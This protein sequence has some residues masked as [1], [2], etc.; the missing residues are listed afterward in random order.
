M[1]EWNF[2]SAF[3]PWPMAVCHSHLLIHVAAEIILLQQW[4]WS[5]AEL[6]LGFELCYCKGTIINVLSFLSL[7]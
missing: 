1:D 3:P 7:L 6:V 5:C 4:T 2:Y